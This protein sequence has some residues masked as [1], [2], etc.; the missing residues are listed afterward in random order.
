MSKKYVRKDVI[1]LLVRDQHNQARTSCLQ[2]DIPLRHRWLATLRS[3]ADLDQA[4]VQ[5]LTGQGG[6][7]VQRV[8]TVHTPHAKRSLPESLGKGR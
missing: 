8:V 5:Y 6:K 7:H 3:L 1:D 2:V 4:W